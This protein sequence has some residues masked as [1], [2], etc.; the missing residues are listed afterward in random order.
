MA[1][2]GASQDD[3]TDLPPCPL[4]DCDPFGGLLTPSEAAVYEATP[5]EEEESARFLAGRTYS[6]LTCRA[7]GGCASVFP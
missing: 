6:P 5:G 3:V 2:E 4:L 7:V 1:E